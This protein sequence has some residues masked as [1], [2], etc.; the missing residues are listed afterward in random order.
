MVP[1]TAPGSWCRNPAKKYSCQEG[2]DSRF[3][4]NPYASRGHLILI[5]RNQ[6]LPQRKVNLNIQSDI[7]R[8]AATSSGPE[9]PFLK[10]LN[11]V[12]I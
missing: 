6:H 2:L 1:G 4:G 10:R 11:G 12:L 7:D 3:R 5:P 8:F 9:L